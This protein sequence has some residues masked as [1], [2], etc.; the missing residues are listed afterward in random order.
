MEILSFFALL[1][2]TL[3]GYAGGVVAK[4]AKGISIYPSLFDIIIVPGIWAVALYFRLTFDINR[5]L[6][7]AFGIIISA[8]LGVVSSFVLERR[9]IEI[10]F[11]KGIEKFSKSFNKALNYWR[12]FSYRM[13]TFQSKIVLSLFFFIFVSPFALGVKLFSNPLRL[14]KEARESFWEEKKTAK[15]DIEQSR[16]QY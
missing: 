3:A 6:I 2:L 7:I 14:K 13:G 4:E 10:D 9:Q 5:W 12:V 16:R 1:L 8:L 11:G 15:T